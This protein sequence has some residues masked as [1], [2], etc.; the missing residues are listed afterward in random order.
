V[1]A[2]EGFQIGDEVRFNAPDGRV[3]IGVCGLVEGVLAVLP[4]GGRNGPPR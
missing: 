2:C 1:Q 4:P 3:F